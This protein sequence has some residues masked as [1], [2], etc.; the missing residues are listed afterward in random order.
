MIVT[1]ASTSVF[2]ATASSA[3]GKLV[4]IVPRTLA[5]KLLIGCRA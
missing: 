3:A 1:T 5:L 4:R 2:T